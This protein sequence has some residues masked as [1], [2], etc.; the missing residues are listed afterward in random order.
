MDE[1]KKQVGRAQMRLTLQRFANLLASTLSV[2]FLVALV[3]VTIP[4]LR[5]LEVDGQ[6]WTW[7]WLGGA[8]L[9]GLLSAIF[10]TLATRGSQLEAAI[11][12]DSRFGLKERVSS[13]LALSE[14]ELQTSAGQALLEDATRRVALVEVSEQFR[15]QPRWWNL[16]PLAPALAVFLIA[17]FIP[18]AA[19]PQKSAAAATSS[20]A[21]QRVDRTAESLKKKLANRKKQAEAQGLKEASDMFSK[22]EKGVDDMK[23]LGDIDRKKAL[24]KLNNLADEIKQRRDKVGDPDR[25]RQQLNQMKDLK[26]GPAD[27]MG[28]ALKKGDLNKAVQEIMQLSE[29]L[30]A[31]K[32]TRK[33]HQKLAE[34][35][36]QMSEKMSQMA[37]AHEMAKQELQNQID[38]AKA[39]GDKQRAGQLQNKLDKLLQQNAQ[40]AKLNKLANKMAQAADAAQQGKS[41]EAS[42]EMQAAAAQLSEMQG[43]ISE[44]AMLD[45][46]LAELE[47]SKDSMNCD[48]C[49]GAG[50]SE[51]Q[52]P[53][54]GGQVPGRGQGMG[55]GQGQGD[56]PESATGEQFYESK[57]KGKIGKGKAVVTGVAGG[58]NR[59]G[60]ALEEYKKAIRSAEIADEDPLTGARIPKEH[61]EQATDYFNKL[62]EGE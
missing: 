58:P 40:V 37:Q 3:A 48:S 11:E 53:S 20:E 39:S 1:L 9:V 41:G 50:C 8:A 18:D 56:R 26:S 2:S 62:R 33:E 35:L 16:M 36:K 61:R 32:M 38:Q 4:K 51:C 12:L 54:G 29:K 44:M 28:D 13:T 43:E 27:R 45:A 19:A 42:Q 55:E 5:H 47:A 49:E 34:Q 21:K 10:W 59:T 30:K 52:G 57:V 6:A 15:G 24:V 23:K 46:A 14:E 7:T 25:L 31:G 22:I 17:V 60:P